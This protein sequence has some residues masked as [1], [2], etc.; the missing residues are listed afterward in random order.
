MG[1]EGVMGQNH[2]MLFQS[3]EITTM[4]E[5]NGERGDVTLAQ[6]QL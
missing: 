6:S 3:V 2:P 1:L 5:P 4:N